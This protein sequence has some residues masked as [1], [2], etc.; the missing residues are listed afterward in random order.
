MKSDYTRDV[1]DE[2]MKELK[3]GAFRHFVQFV[4]KQPELALCFRGND[5]ANGKVII[6]QNNHVIWELSLPVDNPH[7]NTYHPK[8]EINANHA[9]FLKNWQEVVKSLMDLGFRG[10]KGADYAKLEKDKALVKRSIKDKD[11]NPSYTYN[12]GNLTFN[13]KDREKTNSFVDGKFTEYFVK[14]SFEI[15]A[16]MQKEYFNPTYKK[17]AEKYGMEDRPINFFKKYYF[18]LHP[19]KKDEDKN[20][21]LAC[22]NQDGVEKHAQHKLFLRNHELKSG[23]FVYDLEFTQPAVPKFNAPAAEKGKETQK[24]TN[25]KPDMFGIRFDDKGNPVAICMIEVKSTESALDKNSG[26]KAHFEGMTKYV[27]AKRGKSKTEPETGISLM[28]DRKK[29][30]CNILNQYRELGLYGVEKKYE[31]RAFEN[32]P[33]EII[34]AFTHDLKSK[35]IEKRKKNWDLPGEGNWFHYEYPTLKK[36]DDPA[37]EYEYYIVKYDYNQTC[38]E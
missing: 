38:E 27:K 29:E 13:P 7:K 21:N 10:P 34:L 22:R 12:I 20:K 26:V 31:K 4:K 18:D 9:R 5:T 15:L 25:N 8:V 23:I 17:S 33:V 14:K 35:K 16:E 2:M 30:A 1:S 36:V 19:D 6:Y 11:T 3:E 24:K 32:L 37:A 28:E